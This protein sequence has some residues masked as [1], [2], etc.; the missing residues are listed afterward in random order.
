MSRRRRCLRQH[1]IINGFER[2]SR[3]RVLGV[4]STSGCLSISDDC[5]ED[6]CAPLPSPGIIRIV[7]I[8][9]T[10]SDLLFSKKTRE[11]SE[12]TRAHHQR[13]HPRNMKI[14]RGQRNDNN[15]PNAECEAFSY[16]IIKYALLSDSKRRKYY[17][18]NIFKT[19]SL[20]FFF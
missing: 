10:K 2:I 7:S 8:R 19:K 15:K 4:I 9:S 12:R 11:R 14:W 16:L 18:L 1:D 6:A 5:F 20:F 13:A 17:I 3:L